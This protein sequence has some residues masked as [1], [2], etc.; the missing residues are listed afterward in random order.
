MRAESS[1]DRSRVPFSAAVRS[2]AGAVRRQRGRRYRLPTAAG[3]AVVVSAA[4]LM[5]GAASAVS[6]VTPSAVPAK[7]LAALGRTA[8]AERLT[9][10]SMAN[11]QARELNIRPVARSRA[12]SH[13]NV[14]AVRAGQQYAQYRVWVENSSPVP[15]EVKLYW[16]QDN[17]S[18]VRQTGGIVRDISAFPLAGPYEC[19][20]VR[21]YILDIYYAGA[22]AG[23]TGVVETANDWDGY[24]CDDGWFIGGGPQ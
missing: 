13:R 11:S 1:P 22:W 10:G 14:H 7:T 5:G 3:L 15:V 18:G 24:P 12:M 21:A 4:V 8:A 16:V 20:L 2:H 9:S 6:G 23:T 19:S 17:M